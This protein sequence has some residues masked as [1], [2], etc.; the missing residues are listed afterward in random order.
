MKILHPI[1]GNTIPL[2]V[3]T[4]QV[5]PCTTETQDRDPQILGWGGGQIFGP[6][7]P[8]N[9]ADL[10]FRNSGLC[11]PLV[12]LFMMLSYHIEKQQYPDVFLPYPRNFAIPSYIANHKRAKNRPKRAENGKIGFVCAPR[13]EP[14]KNRGPG[15]SGR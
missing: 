10:D 3:F 15:I 8:K 4:R 7:H 5:Q 14:T 12:P 13:G 2:I 1:V 11:V 9:S 6:P